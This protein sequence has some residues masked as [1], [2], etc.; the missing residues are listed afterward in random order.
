MIERLK[1]INPPCVPFLVSFNKYYYA[2][3]LGNNLANFTAKKNSNGIC[4]IVL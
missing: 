1:S 2:G 3:R 4:I